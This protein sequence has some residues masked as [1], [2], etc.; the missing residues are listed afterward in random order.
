MLLPPF[1]FRCA[2]LAI[3]LVALPAAQQPAVVTWTVDELTREALIYT[4]SDDAPKPR[5][6]IFAFHGHGG[7]MRQ[8]DR[9]FSYQ[10]QWP[11][12]VIVYPQGLPT[13]GQLT[14]PEGKR[15]GWQANIGDQGDRDLRFFDSMLA[16][17]FE[18]YDADKTRIYSTGHSNGGGF[19][20]LLAVA[21]HQHFAAIA[22]SSATGKVVLQL[23]PIPVFHVAGEKDPLVKFAWQ[24]LA[25]NTVRKINQCVDG[26]AWENNPLCTYYASPI[27]A[28]VVTCIHPG[29]HTFLKDA[30][31]LIVRFFKTCTKKVAEPEPESSD[32]AK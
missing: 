25:I 28:P 4:P 26:V 11:E 12:A 23:K 14:D 5:P 15:N 6:V 3:F 1:F 29:N 7:N 8:A 32:K 27:G 31:E 2:L 18:R 10:A 30:P 21:R 22:P 13:P 16:T 17:L 24:E 9:S 19:T 20:Y